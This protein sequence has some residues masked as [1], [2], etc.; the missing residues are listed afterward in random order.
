VKLTRRTWRT[1]TPQKLSGEHPTQQGSLNKSPLQIFR[2]VTAAN[3]SPIL[4][5]SLRQ[6]PNNR[7]PVLPKLVLDNPYHPVSTTIH[8][9]QAHTWISYFMV[10]SRN[11]TLTV[12]HHKSRCL[13]NRSNQLRVLA[14]H[15]NNQRRL[16]RHT[17]AFPNYIFHRT[18]TRHLKR[19]AINR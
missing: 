9:I 6:N 16:S 3:N 8:L 5:V 12:K 1:T 7:L 13:A 19:Q 15:N 18:A 10:S 17:Q 11:N 4:S 2:K 14:F